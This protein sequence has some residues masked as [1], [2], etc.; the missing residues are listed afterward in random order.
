M[1]CRR[2]PATV[3]ARRHL[4]RANAARAGQ[5]Q[6]TATNTG[7]RLGA[8]FSLT[9][10]GATSWCRSAE[11]A[12]PPEFPTFSQPFVSVALGSSR[13]Q[14]PRHIGSSLKTPSIWARAKHHLTCPRGTRHRGQMESSPGPG[15][16]PR[17]ASYRAQNAS[18]MDLMPSW[19]GK[20]SHSFATG[21]G[22]RK[23]S[24]ARSEGPPDTPKRGTGQRRC[25]RYQR[26]RFLP[27][28]AFGPFLVV[29]N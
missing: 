13:Q 1:K 15:E 22:V 28:S 9:C 6:G 10:A 5:S 3:M 19:P 21:S 20:D 26:T 29:R 16:C 17:P 12:P 18:L 24:V 23:R 4:P 7:S 25:W 11:S 8:L 14:T 27:I 2:P